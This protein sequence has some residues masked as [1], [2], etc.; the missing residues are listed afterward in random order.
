MVVVCRKKNN[1]DMKPRSCKKEDEENGK[2][3]VGENL[4]MGNSVVKS[5]VNG[6][7]RNES[8]MDRGDARTN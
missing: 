6:V 7:G 3:L 5:Q 2:S 8:R 1:R 4:N